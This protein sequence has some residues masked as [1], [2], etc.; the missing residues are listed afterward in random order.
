VVLQNPKTGYQFV[1]ELKDRL[2]RDEECDGWKEIP[3]KR[4]NL[5]VWSAADTCLPGFLLHKH[6]NFELL[7]VVFYFAFTGNIISY[8]KINTLAI[9]EKHFICG[10]YSTCLAYF[11]E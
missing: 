7:F 9:N 1:F 4:D 11:R 6:F 3:L 5:W 8:L 2:I 10:E